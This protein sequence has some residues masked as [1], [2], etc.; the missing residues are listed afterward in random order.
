MIQIV[1]EL[2][3]ILDVHARSCR[4]CDWHCTQG[5][6]LNYC[7]RQRY[8]C[9]LDITWWLT[10]NTTGS[11]SSSSSSAS[12]A[13]HVTRLTY[14]SRYFSS[15]GTSAPKCSRRRTCRPTRLCT[16]TPTHT[17]THTHRHTHR[18]TDRQTDG[19]AGKCSVRWCRTVERWPP[20]VLVRMTC[21]E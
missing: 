3:W 15:H 9:I 6:Q 2:L 21:V 7:Q 1:F 13:G 14:P 19:Q 18:Q 20:S 8:K 12:S 17:D 10:G 4:V 16:R 5:T 11:S